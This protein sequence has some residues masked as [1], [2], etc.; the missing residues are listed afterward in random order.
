[1]KIKSIHMKNFR[2][3]HECTVELE[4]YTALVGANGSGKSTVL[5]A[6]NIF[7]REQDASSTNVIDLD[8][9]DFHNRNTRDPI[10][11]TVTFDDLSEAAKTDFAEYVRHDVLIVTARAEFNPD[12]K[13]ASVRQFGQRSAMPDFAPFFKAY[14]DG[15]PAGECRA[16]YEQLLGKYGADLPKPGAKDAMRDALR[17]Y[18]EAH[19]ESCELI[20]SEDQFYGFSK[21]ANRLSRHVQ[22]IYLPAIKDATKENVEAKNTALGKIL[23]RTVRA[24]VNFGDEISKLKEETRDRYRLLLDAQQGALAEISKSLSERLAHFAHPEATARLAWMEDVKKS[25]QIDEPMARLFAGEGNFEGE[26]ARFGHGLQRSYLLALLQELATADDASAPTLLLAIEE[27]ELFQHPPQARYLADV[28]HQL[29]A[30]NAQIVV[31]SHSPYFVSGRQFECVRMVR[32]DVAAKR[33]NITSLEFQKLADRI[34]AVTGEKPEKPSAR[35]ARLHQALQPHLTEMFFAPRVVFVE[36][37]ED[38]AY[39][40]SWLVLTD[41]WNDFRRFGAHF[42]PVNGKGYLLEPLIVAEELAIPS[43][44]IFDADGDK[45]SA[46]ERPKHE[47]DNRNLLTLMGGNAGDPFPATVVWHDRFVQWP[48]N[49]GATLRSEVDGVIWDKTFGQVTKALGNPAGSFSKNPVH[50]AMHLESLA[51][52]NAVPASLEK[53]VGHILTFAQGQV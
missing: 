41:R 4:E 48:I 22:W 21:G 8:E 52:E 3:F 40:T 1:V 51:K 53:L 39:L 32:R 12:T 14:N 15:R 33:S 43:L 11:I 23:A 20:P 47:A 2:S 7:F 45:T 16:L 49:L 44:A 24:K 18:E 34:S 13:I 38:V 50:I 10:E 28:L 36:G 31:S 46:N 19:P 26:L 6:L 27:P 9:E 5:C 17:A 29:C 42:I 37:L 30:G 35:M 25:V